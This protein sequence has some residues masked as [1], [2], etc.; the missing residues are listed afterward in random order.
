MEDGIEVLLAKTPFAMFSNIPEKLLELIKANKDTN[1]YTAYEFTSFMNHL[2]KVF[3]QDAATMLVKHPGRA[4]HPM[5][6]QLA[7]FHMPEWK[8]SSV[9][10]NNN[11]NNNNHNDI[12]NGT[13]THRISHRYT[14]T[15]CASI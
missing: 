2:N 6:R 8:V 1:S 15:R 10:K 12:N 3:I 14:S 5:F 7:V 13:N 11:N 4:N 9:N